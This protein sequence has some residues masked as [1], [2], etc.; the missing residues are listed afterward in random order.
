MKP[1]EKLNNV[2]KAKLLHGLFRSEILYFL[3]FTEKLCET[4]RED[5]MNQRQNWSNDHIDFD[6][7]LHIVNQT[8]RKIE[9]YGIKLSFNS[10]LFAEQLFDGYNAMYL[11]HCLLL[12]TNNDRKHKN[13]K[14]S[15]AINILFNPKP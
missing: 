1:L 4:I 3:E 5:E 6:F 14:F 13:E 15:M 12:Y 11:S 7:W 2:E 9:Q 8:E 10:K